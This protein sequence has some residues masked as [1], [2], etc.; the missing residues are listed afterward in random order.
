ME[1][2]R[3]S[4]TGLDV[5]WQRLQIISQNLANI[6]STRDAAGNTYRPLTLVSG[7]DASFTSL[8][9][10]TPDS[11]KPSGVRVMGI[12]AEAGALKRVHEPA[13]PHADTDG[14]VTY[15]DVDHASEMTRMIKASRAYEAN[16]TAISIAQQMYNR[17]LEIGRTA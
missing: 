17:A 12:E 2:I 4:M 13:H 7:P 3:I 8:M 6:N 10:G 5:E 11:L 9:Q 16:L 15:P 14:Y 1:A